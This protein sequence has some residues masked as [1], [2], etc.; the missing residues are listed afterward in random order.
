LQRKKIT[1]QGIYIP[2]IYWGILDIIYKNKLINNIGEYNRGVYW[3]IS[4]MSRTTHSTM[5]RYVEYNILLCSIILS[6]YYNILYYP[7]I[8]LKEYNVYLYIYI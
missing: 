1:L 3:G 4:Y 8:Y 2:W 7:Y 5:Y 6:Y